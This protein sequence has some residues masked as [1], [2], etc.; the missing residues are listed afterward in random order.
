MGRWGRGL[1]ANKMSRDVQEEHQS[2]PEGQMWN[3]Q[4]RHRKHKWAGMACPCDPSKCGDRHHGQDGLEQ[5][6][7]T[8]CSSSSSSFDLPE[9]KHSNRTQKTKALGKR[10]RGA[11]ASNPS[12]SLAAP[13]SEKRPTEV[14][15]VIC[16]PTLP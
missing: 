2:L 15:V 10:K 4:C 6:L 5:A 7:L 9:P 13:L 11:L 1:E 12:L 16:T 3:E 14:R 8:R